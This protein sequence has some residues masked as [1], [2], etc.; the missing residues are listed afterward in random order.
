MINKSSNWGLVYGGIASLAVAF[1]LSL[2]WSSS[3]PGDL[4]ILLVLFVPAVILMGGFAGGFLFGLVG[5]IVALSKQRIKASPFSYGLLGSVLSL[6]VIVPFASW[7]AGGI[8]PAL[9]GRQGVYALFPTAL[10]P[11]AVVGCLVGWK[12]ASGE[13]T[14]PAFDAK[15]PVET[16]SSPLEGGTST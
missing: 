2:G 12:V 14:D 10:L 16:T 15:H 5:I 1:C 6:G 3:Q 11:V 8:L 7:V 13:I 9:Q 4:G